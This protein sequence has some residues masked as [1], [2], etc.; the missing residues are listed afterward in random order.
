M[1]G[2]FY[3][4]KSFDDRGNAK[5]DV[6]VV[7][8]DFT[9]NPF[10][11]EPGVSIAQDVPLLFVGGQGVMGQERVGG[12]LAIAVDPRNSKTVFVAFSDFDAARRITR[13]HLRRSDNGKDFATDL[14]VINGAKN[15]ALAVNA[16]GMVAF[17]YQG[18]AGSGS[19][20][21]WRTVLE[22]STDGAHFTRQVLATAPSSEPR[23]AGLPY[24]GDYLHLVS[25]GRDFYGIFS[26]SNAPDDSHFPA[27][28][29]T[30]AH[31]IDK[32]T[33]R[34]VAPDGTTVATSIDPF[35][36]HVTPVTP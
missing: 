15:P 28:K 18:V 4:W 22:T 33:K 20:Q 30:Y 5:A 7:R 12:D 32:N 10:E 1:Y 29:P 17:L 8:D 23:R 6:T 11:T 27:V 25:V 35:F 16:D 13:L 34:L 3:H 2:I 26:F 31:K 9:A 24:L 21:Q 19:N 36:L 14:E